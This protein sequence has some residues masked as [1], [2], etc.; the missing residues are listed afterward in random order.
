MNPRI[1]TNF[2]FKAVSPDATYIPAMKTRAEILAHAYIVDREARENRGE[3]IRVFGSTRV[4]LAQALA[5]KM[6][7]LARDPYANTSR[8]TTH[9]FVRDYLVIKLPQQHRSRSFLLTA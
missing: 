4:C 3:A 1:E 2:A 7:R 5:N 9:R 6:Y 8:R